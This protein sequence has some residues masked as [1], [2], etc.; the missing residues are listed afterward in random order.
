MSSYNKQER[1]VPATSVHYE[2]KVLKALVSTEMKNCPVDAEA[3]LCELKASLTATKKHSS[4]TILRKKL[5]GHLVREL[6]EI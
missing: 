6:H 2:K 3:H 1:P 4:A 5:K